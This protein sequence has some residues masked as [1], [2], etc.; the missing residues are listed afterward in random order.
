M[1]ERLR[2]RRRRRRRA[3]V[4]EASRNLRALIRPQAPSAGEWMETKRTQSLSHAMIATAPVP[5]YLLHLQ[6][7]SNFRTYPRPISF[8]QCADVH[9]CTTPPAMAEG[10]E[11]NWLFLSWGV[12]CPCIFGDVVHGGGRIAITVLILPYPSERWPR[13]RLHQN[14]V[15]Q[16]CRRLG[17]VALG[18]E[19]S[20][21]RYWYR[22]G[23]GAELSTLR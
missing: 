3:I 2:K 22:S 23:P 12:R 21:K 18:W 16:V 13:L 4:R 20:S 19:L 5:Q 11:N 9:G 15:Y 10:C 1:H 17:K 8:G 14:Q 6:T 7:G